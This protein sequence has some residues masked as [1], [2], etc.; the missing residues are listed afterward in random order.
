[1]NIIGDSVP[2]GR[3]TTTAQNRLVNATRPAER[4]QVQFAV[5]RIRIA[6]WQNFSGRHLFVVFNSCIQSRLANEIRPV[7]PQHGRNGAIMLHFS[8]D[9]C[10]CP[11]DEQRYVVRLECFPAFDPDQLGP[12][13]LDQDH[14]QEI[15]DILNQ[16]D[17]VEESDP[18]GGA[19]QYRF[20]LCPQCYRKF[21]KDPL[22]REATRRLKF[23]QN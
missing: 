3:W 5:S 11:L 21:Q 9:L 12:M 20:D 18:A 13:D 16:G 23:S 6:A 4:R 19:K 1:M 10:G 22:G 7:C 8:C 15:A 14:L 2:R 17:A